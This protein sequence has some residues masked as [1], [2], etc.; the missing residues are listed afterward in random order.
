MRALAAI[1][2][3]FLAACGASDKSAIEKVLDARDQAISSHDV[4]GYSRL[5]AADY[6]DNG[7]SKV[8]IVAQM[9]NLFDHFDEVRMHS[10]DR[11]I[12]LLDEKHAECRQSYRL[13]VRSGKHW[14]KMVQRE[15]L[16]FVRSP[17][18]WEISGGL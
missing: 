16:S 2:C 10:F 6:H 17:V 18:G 9:I 5:I 15:Q 8:D 7:H 12:R 1:C 11:D 3:L 4:G 13:E 14:Q